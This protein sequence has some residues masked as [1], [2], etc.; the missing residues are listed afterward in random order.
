MDYEKE[1][2]KLKINIIPNYSSPEKAIDGFKAMNQYR[3]W[4]QRKP[5]VP[6]AVAYDQEIVRKVLFHAKERGVSVLNGMDAMRILGAC[7]FELPRFGLAKDPDAAVKLAVEVGYPVA[8]KIVSPDI[9]HKTEFGVVKVGLH[10]E[11]AL[12]NAYAEIMTNVHS[13]VPRAQINGVMVQALARGQEVILGLKRDPQFG[14]VIMFG[15]GGIY[16][17]VLKDVSFQVAPITRHNAMNMIRE[18]RG[19]PML[20]G[21]R[22][23]KPVDIDAIA[24]GLRLLSQLASDFNEI[25]ELD[26]NPL[27]VAEGSRGAI[28]VDCRIMVD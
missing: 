23:A 8:I 13:C 1:L 26:I 14:A 28:A 15:L 3:L 12:R 11:E 18:I 2:T 25:S 20:A 21:A 6:L 4:L 16:A 24:N 27:F 5:E 7:G 17:E 19:Y 22:G 9:V 10:T